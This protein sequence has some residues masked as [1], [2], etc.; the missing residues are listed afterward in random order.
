MLATTVPGAPGDGTPEFVLT[1]ARHMRPATVRI[2]APRV[3]GCA[4][5]QQVDAVS[6]H[7]YRYGPRRLESLA[8]NAILPALRAH[9][10]SALQLPGL[11]LGLALSTIREGRRWKP[12]VI[13]AHWILPGGLIG[14]LV[15]RRRGVP[16]VI[17]AHGADAYALNG[18]MG[19]WIKK[20][21]LESATLVY[22]VSAEIAGRLEALAPGAQVRVVPVGVDI[23]E[24]RVRVGTR[25]PEPGRILFVGRLADKKGVETLLDAAAQ[26][27]RAY[28]LVI[29]GDGPDRASLEQQA[30]DLGLSAITFLGHCSA[31]EIA[32]EYQRAA[33]AV[34]P[35]RTSKTGDRDGTPVVLM[36]AMA[37]G[38]PVVA[39]ALGGIREQ[40]VDEIDALLVP[41]G[42]APALA[43]AITRA[44]DRPDLAA[45]RAESALRVAM[46]TL[47]AADIGCRLARDLSEL[48]APAPRSR[49]EASDGRAPRACP[50]TG[51]APR[52]LRRSWR[53]TTTS[54]RGRAT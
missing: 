30:T 41:E 12:D 6:L 5:E 36:E 32:R 24:L 20:R 16:L 13:H 3:R 7:R 51:K 54:T 33:I 47:D 22:A 18:L 14:A 48:A 49:E 19:R 11:L 29:A 31:Q 2:V 27:D 38:L 34:L 4:T 50:P 10:W 28:D 8:D 40:A 44:L 37:V 23:D 26:L 46:S 52:W 35:S 25:A 42:D 9:P 45:E 15:A 43:A 53:A 39:T 21:V 17:T 1:L